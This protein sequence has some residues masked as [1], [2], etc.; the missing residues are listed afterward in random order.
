MDND[1]VWNIGIL[2]LYK[3]ALKQL[4]ETS[5]IFSFSADGPQKH[6]KNSHTLEQ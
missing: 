2:K 5:N 4:K 1:L 3:L 6:A